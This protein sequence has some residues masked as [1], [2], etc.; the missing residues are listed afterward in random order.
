MSRVQVAPRDGKHRATVQ[1]GAGD[2]IAGDRRWLPV[3]KDALEGDGVPGPGRRPACGHG[4][5]LAEPGMRRRNG[6]TGVASAR[7]D[8]QI[9]VAHDAGVDHVVV[10]PELLV[11]A[12]MDERHAG[13]DDVGLARA[14][15]DRVTGEDRQLRAGGGREHHD[16]Q[17]G[18]RAD[19]GRDTASVL[20]R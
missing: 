7:A 10:R 13:Q 12:M 4:R 20:L 15:V 11:L 18:Q 14:R 8:D 17:E 6:T 9:D 16:E 2:R 1:T 19:H 5:R 3:R